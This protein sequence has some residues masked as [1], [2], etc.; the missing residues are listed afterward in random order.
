MHADPAQLGLSLDAPRGHPSAQGAEAS[1]FLSLLRARGLKSI[2]SL[3]LTKNSRTMVSFRGGE[4]RVH[5]GYVDAKPEVL[6]AIVRLVEGRTKAIRRDAG[7]F[8]VAH[9]PPGVTEEPKR[10]E[11]THADDEPWSARL[12]DEHRRLNAERFG[13]AL[14]PIAVR[15]SR[16]MMSRLGHYSP[17][18]GGMPAEIAISRRH[19]R[20]H[21]WDDALETL[22][23]EMVHQWQA[24]TGAPLDHGPGFRR[25]A[26]EV[27]IRP[28]ARRV[29]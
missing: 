16:R 11:R 8:V 3:T 1:A 29:V 10:R 18:V 23:H 27:G 24:E 9:S 26:R 4:M 6:D 20:R 21:G 28:R 14:A 7:R 12:V 17:A 22:V 13:G 19:I 15:V 25:K 2:T 5:R